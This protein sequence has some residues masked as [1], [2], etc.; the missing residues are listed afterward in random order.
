MVIR[1]KDLLDL[2]DCPFTG[3]RLDLLKLVRVI[4]TYGRKDTQS[5]SNIL[6]IGF[7]GG[8]NQRRYELTQA[9]NDLDREKKKK[10]AAEKN[11][12]DNE[13]DDN[14]QNIKHHITAI[15]EMNG[16]QKHQ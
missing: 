10:A 8:S 11:D 5:D 13:C 2:G 16:K 3:L 14:T 12:N 6:D 15:P 7:S 4:D 1:G 9:I